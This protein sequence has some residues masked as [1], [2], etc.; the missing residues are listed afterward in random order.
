V[1]DDKG[2]L[3]NFKNFFPGVHEE[4]EGTRKQM[5][6]SRGNVD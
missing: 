3:K 5:Y 2:D 6:S 1:C 4:V